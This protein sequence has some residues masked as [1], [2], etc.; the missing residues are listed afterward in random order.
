MFW[1]WYLSRYVIW[2]PVGGQFCA[3]LSGAWYEMKDLT[4]SVTNKK[5]F[6]P[7]IE[8]V[9]FWGHWIYPLIRFIWNRYENRTNNYV[10]CG[11]REKIIKIFLSNFK[12][13]VLSC[14]VMYLE[15]KLFYVKKQH[16][17]C[18]MEDSFC[19]IYKE[20]V[21]VQPN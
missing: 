19:N 7:W 2:I 11:V 6:F 18:W 10:I 5:H 13:D 9:P 14:Y 1:Q 20:S 16:F 4:L 3:K 17:S 15:L 8:Y 12:V 21:K